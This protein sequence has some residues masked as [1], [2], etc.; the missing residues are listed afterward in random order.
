MKR[1]LVV[2]P[3][4]DIGQM[5]VKL[6]TPSPAESAEIANMIAT[7][8]V[9]MRNEC[10]AQHWGNDA[11]NLISVMQWATPPPRPVFPAPRTPWIIS[12]VGILIGGTGL[13]LLGKRLQPERGSAQVGSIR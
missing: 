6:T 7:T 5:Q 13:F 1:Y 3:L 11:T 4:R 12:I 2:V 10:L 9:R 8:Y